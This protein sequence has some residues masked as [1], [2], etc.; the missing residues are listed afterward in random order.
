MVGAATAKPHELK[1]VQTRRTD[2]K[3][4]SVN[5]STRWNT[6]LQQ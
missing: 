3:L 4:D 5:D 6:M 1:H 2:S